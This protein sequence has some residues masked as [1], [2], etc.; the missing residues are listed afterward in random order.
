MWHGFR[1]RWEKQVS[2]TCLPAMLFLRRTAF[3]LA[4]VL[5][6][7]GGC[8][9]AQVV[10]LRPVDEADE[11]PSFFSFRSRLLEAVARRDTAFLFAHTAPEVHVSFGAENGLSAFKRQWNLDSSPAGSDLWP[12]LARVVGAGGRFS[13]SGRFVA[14]YV[15]SDWPDSLDAFQHVAVVGED[16]RVRASPS[17]GSLVRARLS[18]AV[19][20]LAEGHAERTGDGRAWLKVRL[21]DGREGYVAA[22]YLQSPVGYRA[23]FEKRR[24]KWFLAFFVAGD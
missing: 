24:G 12:T 17:T 4:V 9:A 21:R 2:A 6:L 10:S 19:V 3:I 5:L 8:A 20:P 11:E 22:D 15:Y 18:F 23:G 14:P 13:E 1:C 16:V 7:T